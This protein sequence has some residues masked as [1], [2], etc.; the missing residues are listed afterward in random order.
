MPYF[1][2]KRLE[3]RL[4][5]ASLRL[6]AGETKADECLSDNLIKLHMSL[7]RTN[8][9]AE[10]ALLQTMEEA[11]RQLLQQRDF[12]S[13][14]ESFQQQLLRDLEQT[15]TEGQSYLSLFLR[16]IGS[17]TQ[18]L[19]KKITTATATIE[20]LLVVLGQVEALFIL[21]HFS[22]LN[23]WNR[24]SKSPT[25]MLRTS[26]TALTKLSAKHFRDLRR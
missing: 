18:T 4:K 5:R 26:T 23:S 6:K 21:S 13:Y 17:A 12:A 3:W 25:L 22:I 15:R 9:D 1:C 2:V 7:I 10:A 24:T 8:S 11:G 14:I 20:E 16:E 19:M